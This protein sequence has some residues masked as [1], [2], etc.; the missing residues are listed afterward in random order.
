MCS[1]VPALADARADLQRELL[2]TTLRRA[3]APAVPTE[4]SDLC[5]SVRSA[6]ARVRG[7]SVL[8]MHW[9]KRVVNPLI[10]D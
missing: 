8:S 3:P 9:M 5:A 7:R 4:N 2:G 6:A 1:L 10:P